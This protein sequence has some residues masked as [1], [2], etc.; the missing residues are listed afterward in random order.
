L[1][2]LHRIYDRLLS[3]REWADRLRGAF[4]FRVMAVLST[5]LMV[6]VGLVMVRSQSWSGCWLVE[7]SLMGGVYEAS[8]W[9]PAQVPLLVGLVVL[10]HLFSG[11]R[12]LRCGIL[13]LPP[14][15]RAATYVAAVALVVVFGPGTTKAFIYFQ[16]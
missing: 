8:N 9:V 4:A 3:G 6:A 15:V 14:L 7:R 2:V 12:N 1:L 11:L 16:F 5:F 13:E 10:G